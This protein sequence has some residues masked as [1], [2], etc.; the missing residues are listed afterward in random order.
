MTPATQFLP[1]LYVCV[2]SMSQLI[3]VIRRLNIVEEMTDNRLRSLELEKTNT[4]QKMDQLNECR[5]EVVSAAWQGTGWIAMA[6]L[7]QLAKVGFLTRSCKQPQESQQHEPDLTS[8]QTAADDDV[9][10]LASLSLPS[11]LLC[12]LPFSRFYVIHAVYWALFLSFVHLIRLFVARFRRRQTEG[13]ADSNASDSK[14]FR[15]S[16]AYSRVLHYEWKLLDDFENA[17]LSTVV[18]AWNYR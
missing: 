1:G 2:C 14:Q 16:S 13:D 11:S 12:W 17:G 4:N 8:F 6:K 15:T 10:W 7:V 9:G 5:K 3:N 18:W